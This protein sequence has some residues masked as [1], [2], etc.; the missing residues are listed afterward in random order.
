MHTQRDHSREPAII[1]ESSTLEKLKG[2]LEGGVVE[3]AYTKVSESDEP[4]G[5]ASD[6]CMPAPDGAQKA[7][8]STPDLFKS[9]ARC[10]ASLILLKE[11]LMRDA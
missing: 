5:N 10:Q 2:W 4:G 7:E 6:A 11:M 3:A 8:P 9:H 1:H